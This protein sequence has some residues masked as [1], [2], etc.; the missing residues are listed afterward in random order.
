MDQITPT[1]FTPKYKLPKIIKGHTFYNA[2][3]LQSTIDDSSITNST[4]DSVS[5]TNSTMSSSNLDNVHIENS[6]IED[7]EITNS[8]ILNCFLKS[9]TN[10]FPYQNQWKDDF[11]I[12]SWTFNTGNSYAIVFTSPSNHGVSPN[13]TRGTFTSSLPDLFARYYWQNENYSQITGSY[14]LVVTEPR[15][16]T[17]HFASASIICYYID[18][19][20]SGTPGRINVCSSIDTSS[21]PVGSMTTLPYGQAKRFQVDSRNSGWDLYNLPNSVNSRQFV[22]VLEAADINTSTTMSMKLSVELHVQLRGIPKYE[23][24]NDYPNW[25]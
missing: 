5:I 24:G 22:F 4:L 20:V 12:N 23:N 9:N 13:E 25:P 7:T 18:P 2:T 6:E 11:Y 14:T 17:R 19:G 3:I 21:F 15:T 8:T 1:L 10:I 16:V